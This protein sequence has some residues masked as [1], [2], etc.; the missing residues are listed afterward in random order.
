ELSTNFA[1]QGFYGYVVFLAALSLNLGI[2]NLFPLPVLDGGHLLFYGIEAIRG[3]PLSL[4]YQLMFFRVGI[5]LLLTFMLFVT[6]QDL[7][8]LF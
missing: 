3:R 7:L 1:Q 4:R 8:R 5:V 2:I 6:Y